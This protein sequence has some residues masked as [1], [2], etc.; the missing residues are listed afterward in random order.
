MSPRSS[1]GRWPANNAASRIGADVKILTEYARSFPY[2]VTPSSSKNPLSKSSRETVDAFLQEV[3]STPPVKRTRSRGRLLFAMD[4]TASR[5][6]LWDRACHIQAQMFE[7]T[8]VLGGLD[9]QLAYYRGFMEFHA[10]PW[11]GAA[12][13]LLRHMTAIRCAAG[14]TQIEQVLQH[15]TTQTCEEKINALVF[16]G[17]CMEEDPDR[18]G[19]L[20]GELAILGVPVFV[21]QDG[22]DPIAERTFRNIARLT[23]GAYCRFDA[24]SAAQLRDLL[25]AVAVYAA[26][27]QRALE[28]FG[29]KRGGGVL[30][31][32]QQLTGGD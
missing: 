24:T 18:L 22:Y 3:R 26:G 5:Q 23:R 16:V 15:A 6:P 17:D 30:R 9:V 8:E 4:A 7:E 1:T 11:T 29:A 25:C 2:T 10:T 20:A 13:D 14:Q 31:L 27:G 32:S 19:K 28:D 12:H 21:F